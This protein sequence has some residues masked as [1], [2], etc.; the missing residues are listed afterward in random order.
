LSPPTHCPRLFLTLLRPPTPPLF[1]YTTLF[2]SRAP[3][4]ARRAGTLDQVRRQGASLTAN[5]VADERLRGALGKDPR[6]GRPAPGRGRARQ[7]M[8]VEEVKVQPGA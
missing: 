1:P 4:G 6:R 2:R 7:G 3:Q 5:Q 8:M